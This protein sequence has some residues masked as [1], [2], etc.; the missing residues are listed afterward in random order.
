MLLQH[1]SSSRATVC[2]REHRALELVVLYQPAPV[3]V[4]GLQGIHRAATASQLRQ[5]AGKP[6]DN[7]AP[8]LPPMRAKAQASA[9]IHILPAPGSLTDMI[10]ATTESGRNTPSAKKASRI[11]S[12]DSAPLRNG[13]HSAGLQAL[14]MLTPRAG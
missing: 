6:P 11:S 14:K 13:D 9:Q 3:L 2:S 4:E 5:N 7:S 8:C 1:S 10:C 12:L